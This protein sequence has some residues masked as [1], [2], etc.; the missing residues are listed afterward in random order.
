MP[1]PFFRFE[2]VGS[3]RR[4]AEV[5]AARLQLEKGEKTQEQF[6]EVAYQHIAQIIDKQVE[7]G[8]KVCS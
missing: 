4:P 8:L 3:F 6:E 1:G 5:T 7:A 2:H